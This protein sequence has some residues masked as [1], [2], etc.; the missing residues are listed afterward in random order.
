MDKS[1]SLIRPKKFLIF[2]RIFLQKWFLIE[3]WV[4]FRKRSS[5]VKGLMYNNRAFYSKSPVLID[6]KGPIHSQVGS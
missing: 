5:D 2:G 4:Y 1:L 6:E 3:E